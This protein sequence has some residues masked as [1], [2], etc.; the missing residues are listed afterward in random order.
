MSNETEAPTCHEWVRKVTSPDEELKIIVFSPFVLHYIKEVLP[1]FLTSWGLERVVTGA[2]APDFPPVDFS[3]TG[4]APVSSEV[5][6]TFFTFSTLS[7]T[8]WSTFAGNYITLSSFSLFF[9]IL[10]TPLVWVGAKNSLRFLRFR[11][12]Q[13]VFKVWHLPWHWGGEEEPSNIIR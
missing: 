5:V 13:K 3:L 9:S 10:C 2:F 1:R 6:L 4:F 11:Q 8:P 7:R 12:K